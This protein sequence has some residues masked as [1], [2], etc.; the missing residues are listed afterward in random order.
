MDFAVTPSL[1]AAYSEAT[2]DAVERP[3]RNGQAPAP[4]LLASLAINRAAAG[5]PSPP[6]SIH[7]KQS[8]S[9][10]QPLIADD[11][12]VVSGVV[13]D[14][15]EK[16]GRWYVAVDYTARR[17]NGEVLVEARTTTVWAVPSSKGG[18]T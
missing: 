3:S 13:H 9:F 4:P 11:E 1:V 2:G 17:P 14:V 18:D 6:G 7:A 10:K 12:L 5:L 8:F 16:R 15:Y